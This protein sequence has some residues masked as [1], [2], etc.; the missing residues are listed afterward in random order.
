MPGLW[1]RSG[2]VR[3][4]VTKFRWLPKARAENCA[5][6]YHQVQHAFRT[7]IVPHLDMALVKQMRDKPL[8]FPMPG[9]G[10]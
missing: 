7:T 10:K 2:R 4:F 3:D 9:D 5:T 8:T 6:E 1:Q